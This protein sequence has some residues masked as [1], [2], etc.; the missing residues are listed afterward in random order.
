LFAEA[1]RPFQAYAIATSP[2]ASRLIDSA[3]F[4]H[5]W[6]WGLSSSSFFSARSGPPGAASTSIAFAGGTPSAMSATSKVCSAR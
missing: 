6:M 5:Q 1:T 3:P 2:E 4:F